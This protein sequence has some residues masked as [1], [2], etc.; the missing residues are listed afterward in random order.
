MFA[1]SAFPN[2]EDRMHFHAWQDISMLAV[3]V[4]TVLGFVLGAVWY[5][6]VF[7]KAWMRETGFT[8]EDLKKD[9]DPGK[10][11]GTSFLLGLVAAFL[12]GMVL[13]PA[14]AL[15]Y[16]AGVGFH[17]GLFWIATSFAT[18]YLFEK[19]SGRLFAINAGYHVVQFTLFGVAFGLLG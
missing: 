12:L 10:V 5:G 19:K 18:N 14:P 1:G 3:L 6:P 17:I 15:G 13:G 9:F 16:A 7:G 4:A 11:Y 2:R 8:A